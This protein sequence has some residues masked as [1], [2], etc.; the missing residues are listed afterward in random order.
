MVGE[1]KIRLFDDIFFS[2]PKNSPIE[3]T[4]PCLSLL[5]KWFKGEN[6]SSEFRIWRAFSHTFWW[7]I[8]TGFFDGWYLALKGCNVSSWHSIITVK[9]GKDNAKTAQSRINA[10]TIHFGWHFTRHFWRVFTFEIVDFG[11]KRYYKVD[12]FFRLCINF[13]NL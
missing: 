7:I 8:L 10:S 11:A 2:M 6:V 1:N 13:Q 4:V 3:H 9:L 5:P 12:V